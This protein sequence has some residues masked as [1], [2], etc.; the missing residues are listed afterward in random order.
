MS[1]GLPV[2]ACNKYYGVDLVVVEHV[3]VKMEKAR[4]YSV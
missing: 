1:A 2:A 4:L 3:C